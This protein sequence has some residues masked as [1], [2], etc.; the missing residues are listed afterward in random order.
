[1]RREAEIRAMRERLRTLKPPYDPA[2]VVAA[3]EALE[4]A[5]GDT[6]ELPGDLD[7]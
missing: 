6:D 4:W 7:A 1:M 3:A 5:L 2:V